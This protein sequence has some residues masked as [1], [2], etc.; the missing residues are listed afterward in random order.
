MFIWKCFGWL[1]RGFIVLIITESL[2]GR[3]NRMKV[4]M[5]DWWE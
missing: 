4:D 3:N 1:V 2:V 5:K